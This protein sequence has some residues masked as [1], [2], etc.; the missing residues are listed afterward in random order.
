MLEA[1]ARAAA[2]ILEIF[3]SEPFVGDAARQEP[4]YPQSNVAFAV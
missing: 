1:E 4:I 2:K 3:F